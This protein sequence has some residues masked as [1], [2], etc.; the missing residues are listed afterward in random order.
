MIKRAFRSNLDDRLEV[1]DRDS[2]GDRLRLSG[3]LDLANCTG[4]A[5]CYGDG[6]SACVAVGANAV[7][8]KGSA[9]CTSSD[10]RPVSSVDA[11]LAARLGGADRAAKWN[12]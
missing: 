10:G 6:D 12:L 3:L 5:D 4:V 2:L 11:D 8:R 9:V 1:A 7:G